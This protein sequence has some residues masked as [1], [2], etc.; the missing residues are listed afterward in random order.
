MLS[1]DAVSSA[2]DHSHSQG[3][4]SESEYPSDDGSDGEQW[5][6]AVLYED[7]PDQTDGAD[8]WML[9][10]CILFVDI[11]FNFIFHRE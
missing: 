7:R 5:E 11:R 3:S 1:Q 10:K 9:R 8:F 4:E 6:M 2:E